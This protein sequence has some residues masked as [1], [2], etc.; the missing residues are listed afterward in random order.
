MAVMFLASCG[1]GG[2]KK[3]EAVDVQV[4]PAKTKIKGKLSEFLE[5]VDGTYK[6][7]KGD[8]AFGGDY[9]ILVKVKSIATTKEQFDEIHGSNKGNSG[10]MTLSILDETGLP[11]GG[12]DKFKLHYGEK[13]KVIYLLENQGEEDFLKFTVDISYGTEI[14]ENGLPD[15]INSFEVGSEVTDYKPSASNNSSSSYS[16]NDNDEEESYSSSSGSENWD[17]VLDSYEKY[18]D[19]YIKLLKK[20]Q[21]GDMN[22]MTEYAEMME[23]AT[24]LAEKMENADDDLSPSQMSRFVKLQTKLA[25]AAANL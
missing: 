10:G 16:S 22:A 18:I 9:Q 4:K 5:V 12:L 25:S 21:N 20:A 23:K 1:G 24:D 7:S 8:G 14:Y 15:N 6:I 11:I 2:S 17:A 3:N 13:D 19:Q